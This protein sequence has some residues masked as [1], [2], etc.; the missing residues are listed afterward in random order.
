M[1]FYSDL[2]LTSLSGSKSSSISH[3]PNGT[4]INSGEYD[5]IGPAAWFAQNINDKSAPY[6]NAVTW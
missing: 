3:S 5:F 2:I 1:K 6:F 4:T